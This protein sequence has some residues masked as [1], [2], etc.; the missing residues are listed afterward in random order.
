MTNLVIIIV[1][2][3][4]GKLL[5][6]CLSSITAQTG[7]LAAEVVVVDNASSDGSAE[8]VQREFPLVRLI[9]NRENV[10]FARANNQ[11]IRATDSRYVLLLN[12]DAFLGDQ[13]LEILLSVIE[14]DAKIAAVGPRMY[15][16]QG[17]VLA[18]A[19][20]FE[21]LPKLAAVALRAHTL[22]PA[23]LK[24]LAAP[25]L[26]KSGNQHLAN[27]A[28]REP[29]EVDWLSG[30]CLLVRR[31]AIEQ[32]GGLDE[33]YFMYMEDEDWCRRFHAAGYRALYVAAAEITHQVACS[34]RSSVRSAR[35]YRDSRLLYHR[36]YHPRLYPVFHLLANLYALRQGGLKVL[37]TAS[38]DETRRSGKMVGA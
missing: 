14:S 29:V 25:L 18:S 37:T 16:A 22:L 13:A 11:A 21:T 10:G 5:R 27:F 8:M 9:A 35:I 1:N 12:S 28:A 4:T 2:Y 38:S 32:V 24:K 19:H 33:R 6:R 36:R 30:A 31:A 34:S 15:D 7:P 20:G 17:E 26:G 3:N 23:S